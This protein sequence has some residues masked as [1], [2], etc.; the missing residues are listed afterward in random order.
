M[1]PLL[2]AQK[3]SENDVQLLRSIATQASLAI[4]NANLFEKIQANIEELR[5]LDNMKNQFLANMSHELRT[6]LNSIIGFS[7]VILKGIDGPITPAQEEDLTSIY[8]NGQHLLNLINEILD[9][10]KIEA[11]K[12]TLSFDKVNLGEAAKTTLA[13]IRSLIKPDVELI[14]DIADGLPDI[15]A[16]PIR[17]RQILI[18]LLSNAAKFTD[19]GYISLKVNRQDDDH[20]QIA[21]TDTGLGIDQEDIDKLFR[22]F[23]QVDNSTTRTAGGTGL[24]LPITLWL[25][26]MHHGDLW[27]DTAA[28]KGSTF[29]ISLPIVQPEEPA[30]VVFNA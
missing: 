11:G 9:M 2:P 24:G 27:L 28:G 19:Q 5:E 18:N 15:E 30:N 12:M 7:R 26:K 14:S 1:R 6:P 17:I 29:Y 4:E 25:V 3:L 8:N 16:D 22:A 21:V 10:A 13:N 20:L 23:E